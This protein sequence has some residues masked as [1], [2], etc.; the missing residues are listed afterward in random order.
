[1]KLPLASDPDTALNQLLSF[2]VTQGSEVARDYFRGMAPDIRAVIGAAAE[3]A[4]QAFFDAVNSID[5][6]NGS[7]RSEV[8]KLLELPE[9]PPADNENTAQSA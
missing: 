8:R 6:E 2:L 1:M 3:D 4:R 9:P 7:W 5:L